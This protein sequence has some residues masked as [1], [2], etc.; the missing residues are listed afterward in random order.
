[1]KLIDRRSLSAL[2]LAAAV[3]LSVGAPAPAWAKTRE[4]VAVV[5]ITGI[6][7]A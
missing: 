6:N 7:A 1:M 3:A 4:I 2:G 5:K